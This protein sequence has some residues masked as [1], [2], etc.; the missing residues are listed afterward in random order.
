MKPRKRRRIVAE[1]T[2]PDSDGS[3]QRRASGIFGTDVETGSVRAVGG[4]DSEADNRT[5]RSALQVACALVASGALS[6]AHP[7]DVY[8]ALGTVLTQ[9]SMREDEVRQCLQRHVSESASIETD[10]AAAASHDNCDDSE[11]IEEDEP[12]ASDDSLVDFIEFGEDKGAGYAQ[13]RQW[14]TSLTQRAE[15]TRCDLARHLATFGVD[16]DDSDF[17][18]HD[19]D[20]DDTDS[21]N[22]TDIDGNEVRDLKRHTPRHLAPRR[23]RCVPVPVPMPLMQQQQQQQQQ[24]KQDEQDQFRTPVRTKRRKQASPLA[25][26]AAL[27]TPVSQTHSYTV[28]PRKTHGTPRSSLACISKKTGSGD[29]SSL[30]QRETSASTKATPK[31]KTPHKS[32]PNR[33]T[34]AKTSRKTTPATEKTPSRTSQTSQGSARKRRA[35]KTR[36]TE[37]TTETR[38]SKDKTKRAKLSLHGAK[39]GTVGR[40]LSLQAANVSSR[41]PSGARF[42][43]GFLATAGSKQQLVKP[44][45][46]VAVRTREGEEFCRVLRLFVVRSGGQDKY[47][48]WISWFYRAKDIPDDEVSDVKPGEVFASRHM[49]SLSLQSVVRVV[50]IDSKKPSKTDRLF[51]SRMYDQFCL[52][53]SR[54]VPLLAP[55]ESATRT[56]QA[57]VAAADVKMEEPRSDA[58]SEPAEFDEAAAAAQNDKSRRTPVTH[59]GIKAEPCDDD[60]DFDTNA[61]DVGL[62]PQVVRDTSRQGRTPSG[63]RIQSFDAPTAGSLTTS[64]ECRLPFRPKPSRRRS[65]LSFV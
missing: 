19:K 58:K 18:S 35:R 47:R 44:G 7:D 26:L 20:A 6:H 63:L 25:S 27:W 15:E 2:T 24:L 14:A 36:E 22:D 56:Q 30:S 52:S 46:C 39:W 5:E 29:R 11:D 12:I 13:V 3:V 42:F 17:C 51:C 43:G 1:P 37:E 4:D 64:V 65:S 41:V 48:M 38:K 9:P 54:I 31:R 21:E 23:R 33:K 10:A 59:R 62:G 40:Q 53:G 34:K 60:D 45:D 16:S 61:A 57:H 28:T 55:K 32:Q 8:D 49:Q 50:D